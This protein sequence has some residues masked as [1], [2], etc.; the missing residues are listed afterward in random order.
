MQVIT[1][2][3]MESMC[4]TA[5]MV[6]VARQTVDGRE[7]FVADGKSATPERTFS[8]FGV[9]ANDF[10]GGCYATMYFVSRR[11]DKLDIGHIMFFD[12]FHNP[13]LAHEA[14]QQARINT[15][16]DHAKALL[17]RMKAKVH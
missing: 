1:K 10:P 16:V 13:E 6:P 5:G 14:K 17:S 7:V 11:E 4:R 12:L 15:A 8:K 2:D 3:K 9:E